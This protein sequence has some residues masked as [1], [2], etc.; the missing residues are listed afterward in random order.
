MD[1]LLT[2][3]LL[4]E[5]PN[6]GI[7]S[8][9]CP[10]IVNAAS[11]VTLFNGEL[12]KGATFPFVAIHAVEYRGIFRHNPYSVVSTVGIFSHCHLIF[13]DNLREFFMCFRK[14]APNIC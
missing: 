6:N 14:L 3:E 8:S 9:H 13:D 12:L 4:P 11:L 7:P 2:T 1:I 10:L 5:V